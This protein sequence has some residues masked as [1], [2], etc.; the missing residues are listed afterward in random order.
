MNWFG[1]K[2]EC[3]LSGVLC[4]LRIKV[5]KKNAFNSIFLKSFTGLYLLHLGS[6]LENDWTIIMHH[7]SGE[8]PGTS[9]FFLYYYVQIFFSD[10]SIQIFFFSSFWSI[11]HSSA[12]QWTDWGDTQCI[13]FQNKIKRC[14][15]YFDPKNIFLDDRNKQFLGWPNR[16]FG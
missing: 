4:M 5:W 10:Q 2:D 7:C 12:Q 8:K 3:L 11:I 15:G 9:N 1:R 16:Y 13:C 6:Q 14:F